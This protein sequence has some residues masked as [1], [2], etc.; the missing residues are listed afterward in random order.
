MKKKNWRKIIK[1]SMSSEI[2]CFVKRCRGRREKSEEKRS[3][4]ERLEE[5]EEREWEKF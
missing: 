3:G 2:Q 5:E 4:R 1:R